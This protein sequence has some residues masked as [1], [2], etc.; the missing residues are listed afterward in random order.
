MSNSRNPLPNQIEQFVDCRIKFMMQDLNRRYT[1]RSTNTNR[2][3]GFFVYIFSHYIVT[4]HRIMASSM[5]GAVV[6]VVEQNAA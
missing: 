5:S 3:D 4:R 1:P 6:P 2:L